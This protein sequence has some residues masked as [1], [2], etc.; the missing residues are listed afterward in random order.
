MLLRPGNAGANT[1]ADHIT[2][3]HAAIRQV[4][5]ANRRRLLIRADGAG[6]TH[7]FLDWLVAN[8][9]IRGRGVEFSVGFAATE[10]VRAAIGRLP[11]RASVPAID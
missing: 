6:C 4:A 1:A 9:Q 5:A 8:N 10:A 3:L 11:A 7:D 2:V